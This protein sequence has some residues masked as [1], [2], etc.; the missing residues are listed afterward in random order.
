MA[1]FWDTTSRIHTSGPAYALNINSYSKRILVERVP[2]ALEPYRIVPAAGERR[3]EGGGGQHE[4]A[5][6]VL[7]EH[8]LV[9]VRVG[10]RVGVRVRVRVRVRVS[11]AAPG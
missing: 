11:T 5:R 10:V 3:R 2:D 6:G 1:P 4:P 7:I 8:D 9:R